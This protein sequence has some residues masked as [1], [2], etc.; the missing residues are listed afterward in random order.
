LPACWDHWALLPVDLQS[1]IV[2]SY[3]RGQLK[4]YADGLLEAVKLW[5]QAGAWRS[6]Y[7]ELASPSAEANTAASV[8]SPELR[9]VI[10]LVARRP[11]AAMRRSIDSVISEPERPAIGVGFNARLRR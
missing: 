3:G 9:N 5:R 4:R 1:L 7:R 10:S 6:K 2:T 11:M 8:T